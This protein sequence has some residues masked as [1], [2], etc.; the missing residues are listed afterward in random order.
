M[1][2]I[3]GDQAACAHWLRGS[4]CEKFIQVSAVATITNS[5]SNNAGKSAIRL[6]TLY[7]RWRYP[8]HAQS[9][10]PKALHHKTRLRV[11]AE[12]ALYGQ[13]AWPAT[14]GLPLAHP[15]LCCCRDQNR[16]HQR[17]YTPPDDRY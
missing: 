3:S 12:S 10:L 17:L 8:E 5:A 14:A 1:T 16:A 9:A 15:C 11:R 2:S 6:L 4:A 7:L 13:T